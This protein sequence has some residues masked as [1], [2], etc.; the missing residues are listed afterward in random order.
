MGDAAAIQPGAG[1]AC[2][3]QIFFHCQID[4]RQVACVSP[5]GLKALESDHAQ[6]RVAD[7]PVLFDSTKVAES[8]VYFKAGEGQLSTV[9]LPTH[10][11]NWAC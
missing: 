1:D 8:C 3:A 5:S 7:G 6:G 11:R 2:F 9:L 10:C 4:G